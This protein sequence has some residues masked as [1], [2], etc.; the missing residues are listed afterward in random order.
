M[1]HRGRVS[2]KSHRVVMLTARRALEQSPLPIAVIGKL[3]GYSEASAFRRAYKNFWGLTPT[4][5]RKSINYE[6]RQL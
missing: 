2:D 6:K 1:N 4:T 5:F 3:I